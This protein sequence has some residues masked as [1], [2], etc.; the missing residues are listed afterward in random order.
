[1]CWG[2]SVA[3]II[4]VVERCADGIISASISIISDAA[5]VIIVVVR[6]DDANIIV[7][8]IVWRSVDE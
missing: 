7:V 4:T 5:V 1:M 2:C 8:P 3:I 6:R